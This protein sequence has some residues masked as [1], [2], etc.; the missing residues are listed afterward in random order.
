MERR[1]N[2]NEAFTVRCPASLV[3]V[4]FAAYRPLRGDGL[5][6]MFPVGPEAGERGGG[7]FGHQH[8]DLDRLQLVGC[9][10]GFRGCEKPTCHFSCNLYLI[11]S[12]PVSCIRPA[13]HL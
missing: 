7:H 1:S 13:I 4:E 6:T 8:D 2:L 10:S 11:S 9:F 12:N 5:G 3:K